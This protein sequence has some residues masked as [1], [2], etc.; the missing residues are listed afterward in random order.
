V[1]K[2]LE[3]SESA[4]EKVNSSIIVSG[5]ARSGTS[6]LGRLLHTFKDVEYAYEPP[7][8]ISIISLIDQLPKRQWKMLFEAYLYE[9]VLINSI[10]GRSI[11][12]NRVD[13]SSIYNAKSLIDIEGRLNVTTNKI[14][15]E[16]VSKGKNICFKIP[17]IIEFIPVIRQY[18][19]SIR[20]VLIRRDAI[21][22][23]SSLL[24]KKWFSDQS[25]KGSLL[26]PFEVYRNKRVPFWVD[27]NDY[28]T[29]IL[30]SELDRC[31]YYYVRMNEHMEKVDDYI[32]IKYSEL[33]SAPGQVSDQISRC[34]N[35][36]YGSKTLSVINSIREQPRAIMSHDFLDELD[37]ELKEKVL[38]YSRLSL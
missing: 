16:A 9:E 12:C 27:V 30:M 31:A 35:L 5:C 29:W 38:H 18:Y 26:W 28:D 32:E 4:P 22:N 1:L 36:V 37:S 25:M 24:R 15:A 17:S 34:L 14:D 21:G 20:V 7:A 33:V 6:I 3:V 11:N 19:P 2:N 8:L 13:E 10:A 23:I